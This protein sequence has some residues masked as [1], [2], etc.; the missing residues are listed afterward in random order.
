MEVKELV[1]NKFPH[2]YYYFKIWAVIL[3]TNPGFLF[4]FI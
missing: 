2:Y 1:L 3:K 4:Y